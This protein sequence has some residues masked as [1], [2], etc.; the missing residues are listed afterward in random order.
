MQRTIRLKLNPT[1]EQ[2]RILLETTRQHT[3]CY[4]AVAR[5]GWEQDNK[6]GL[7]L[8]KATYY[9]LRAQFPTLPAQLVISA[10]VRATESLASA[11]ALKK[12]PIK[13]KHGHKERKIACPSSTFAPIRYDAR[14]YRFDKAKQCFSFSTVSGRICVAFQMYGY[15]CKQLAKA[16]G[17]D[18]ADLI[19]Q[20][21]SFFAHLVMTLPDQPATQT[22]QVIGVDFGET[23]PAV[24]SANH[25]FGERRWKGTERRY[26]KHKRRLQSKGTKSAKR[27]LKEL[28]QRVTRFRADC[29]HVVSRRIVDSVEPGTTIVVENLTEIRTTGKRRGPQQRRQFHQWPFKRLR[30]LLTYKAEAKGCNVVGIDPRHTSQTCSQCGYQ[31]KLSRKS[32]SL[33]H[34][35]SCHYQLNADL[36]GSRNIALKYLASAGRSGAGGLSVNPPIVSTE[37]VA[38]SQGQAHS[39]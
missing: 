1:P 18:S 13:T 34:C 37:G 7:E 36:N 6:N 25:F 22:N 33:F 4:N 26:F 38:P 31:H 23:R 28:R 2:V 27:R 32:Q 16:L 12:K 24:T 14:S 35:R 39:L 29:D 3:E 17:F 21:G 15:A 5:Y 9:P 30:E 19:Y 10:R 11:F 8:H 20:D